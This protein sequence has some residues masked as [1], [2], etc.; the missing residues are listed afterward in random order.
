MRRRRGYGH[1]LVALAMIAFLALLLLF[2]LMVMPKGGSPLLWGAR[3]PLVTASIEVEG[4]GSVS[5][6]GTLLRSWNSTKPFALKLEAMPEKC[7]AFRGWLVNG[8]FR[9]GEANLTLT[10]R[11]NTTV[12]AVFERL[13]YRL[14]FA[15]NASWGLVAVNGSVVETPYE[16]EAPCGSLLY[17]TLLAGS[18]ETHGFAPLGFLVNGSFAGKPLELHVYGSANVTALYRVETHVLYIES[19]APG[20]KVLVDGVETLL[21]TK[22]QRPRPFTVHIQ[23]PAFIQVNDT[24]AWG[25]PEIQELRYRWGMG[26]VWVTVAAGSASVRVNGTARVRVLYRP[27]HRVGGALVTWDPGY[28]RYQRVEGSTLVSTPKG[29]IFDF[30]LI[31]PENWKTVKLRL[32]GKDVKGVTVYY[33][34]SWLGG[35]RYA[36]KTADADVQFGTCDLVAEFTVVRDPPAAHIRVVSCALEVGV[37]DDYDVSGP[38]NYGEGTKQYLGRFIAVSGGAYEVRIYV[39]VGG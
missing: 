12:K 38:W 15:S 29:H 5:A 11:G 39:E 28:S 10:V 1:W 17:L 27:T 35:D 2:I 7:W 4:R 8:S 24:F 20:A 16:M 33:P 21:P 9:S 3:Q 26:Y 36:E 32:E 34:Y 37:L 25:S 18:N 19:N 23:A 22:I 30:S 31:L 14:T 6:N 13:R